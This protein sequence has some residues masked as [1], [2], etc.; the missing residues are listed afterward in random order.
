M[1]KLCISIAL[2]SVLFSSKAYADGNC[3]FLHSGD[4]KISVKNQ[5]GISFSGTYRHP[6]CSYDKDALSKIRRVFKAPTGA[7]KP[8]LSMR[9]IEFLDYISDKQT[10]GKQM[11]IL[12]GYRSPSHNGNLRSKGRLAAKASMH[13]YG[14]AADVVFSG[15]NPKDVWDFVRELGFG[16]AG[17]YHASS[18]HIDVGPTRFWDETTTGVDTDASDDNK[19]ITMVTDADYYDPS[20]ELLVSFV[21]MTSFPV[22]I[23]KEFA[24]MKKSKSGDFKQIAKLFSSSLD[25]EC[26]QFWSIPELSSLKL[27]IPEDASSGTYKIVSNFCGDMPEAMPKSA[28]TPEFEV[29]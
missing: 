19:L 15:A 12:S 13:Q 18:V 5:A 17:Y 22:G 16:G 28:K 24:L 26:T 3:G 29:R 20:D 2:I 9:L 27:K 8:P 4:G 14:M 1:K 25:S 23:A 6:D 10:G 21:R 7:E 11:K